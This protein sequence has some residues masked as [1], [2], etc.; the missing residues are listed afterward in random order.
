MWV[1]YLMFVGLVLVVALI[2]LGVQAAQR[3][4]AAGSSTEDEIGA[5][6]SEA[7]TGAR[8]QL[9][10]AERTHRRGIRRA[11]KALAKA[12]QDPALV[13]V[14]PVALHPLAIVLRGVEHQLSARTRFEVEVTGTVQSLV[15]N[16][17]VVSEDHR[18]VYLTVTDPAWGDVVKLKP[19]QLEGARRL[20]V[21][22]E[23]AVR[24][25]DSA[26]ATRDERVALARAELERVRADTTAVD[27]AR[28]TLED[29][30]GAPPRRL[31]LP[32]PPELPTHDEG[33]GGP[34]D[35]PR[36]IDGDAGD[37]VDGQDGDR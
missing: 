6:H 15:K 4:L 34:G 2:V 11:E 19:A 22:G 20:V 18:E 17:N 25:L 29:L 30:E 21:A 26:R 36:R 28:L 1:R 32:G 10:R 33:G 16:G 5:R 23:A 12:G 14:G 8:K 24:N 7:V 37:E 13:S 27:A 31:D 35:G 3:R 9:K